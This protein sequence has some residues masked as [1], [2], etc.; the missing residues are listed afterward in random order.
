MYIARIFDAKGW[1]PQQYDKL[2]ELMNLGG[3]AAP[4][5]LFNWAAQTSEGIRAVDVYAD[6]ASADRL[7]Q[8]TIG[9]LV[10]QLGLPMPQISEFEVH[11][12]LQPQP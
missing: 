9:P 4:G 2:I 5:V 7:A 8:E 3:H 1:T 12:I 11:S 6:R 10:Q